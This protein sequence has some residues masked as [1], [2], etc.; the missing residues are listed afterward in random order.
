[1]TLRVACPDIYFNYSLFAYDS[2][3]YNI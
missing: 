1:V 3:R 2:D